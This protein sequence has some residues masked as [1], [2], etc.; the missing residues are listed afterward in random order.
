MPVMDDRPP[1]PRKISPDGRFYLD[2]QLGW[3]PVPDRPRL[4]RDFW[5]TVAGVA[6]GLAL[7]LATL[8]FVASVTIIR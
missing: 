4:G 5:W 7:L 8:A 6:L 1:R 3:Q 2:P